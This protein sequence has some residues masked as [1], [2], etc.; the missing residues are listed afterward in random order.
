MIDM[1][2][3]VG[4]I[5]VGLLLVAFLLNITG[6]MSEHSRG[7]LS[8]NLVGSLLAA[9]YAWAGHNV[10]FIILELAWAVSAAIRLI[11]PRKKAAA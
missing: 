11:A 8:M 9:W 6:R 1:P 2:V 4:S 7:Y 3:V 5:G 10:P